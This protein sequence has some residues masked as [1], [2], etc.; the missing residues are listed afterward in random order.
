MS[1]DRDAER[2]R[3]LQNLEPV[4]AQAFFW[5]YTSRAQRAKAID[6]AMERAHKASAPVIAVIPIT[7][8]CHFDLSPYEEPDDCMLDRGTPSLCTVAKKLHQEG[9]PKEACRHWK[10]IGEATQCQNR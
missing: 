10:P 6:A 8:G 9:E 2:F 5:N 4:E 7:Y 3:F 1:I